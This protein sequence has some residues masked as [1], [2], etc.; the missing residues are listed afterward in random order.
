MTGLDATSDTILQIACFVTD[1]NLNILDDKGF[2]VVIHH[3]KEALDQMGEW[4]IQHHGESGLTE[5]ALRSNITPDQ[6]AADLLSYI[7][8]YVPKTRSALLAGNTVH[9]D[10]EFLKKGPYGKVI[11]YLHYR[12]LDVSSIK[13]AARRWASIHIL[14]N[15]PEKRKLHTAKE[16]ILESIEEAKYYQMVFFAGGPLVG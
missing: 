15:A 7:Q 10:K 3:E 6:A 12:M 13:E 1:Y 14:Q 2:E 11:D 5:A 9:M 4:C 16:D 8:T